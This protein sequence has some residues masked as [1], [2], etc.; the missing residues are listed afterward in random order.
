MNTKLKVKSQQND[1]KILNESLKKKNE[2][3]Y[4]KGNPYTK[5]WHFGHGSSQAKSQAK[6]AHVN[7]FETDG[8]FLLSRHCTWSATNSSTPWIGDLIR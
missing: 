5:G 2:K 8:H 7:T 4:I 3:I 6:S 1:L